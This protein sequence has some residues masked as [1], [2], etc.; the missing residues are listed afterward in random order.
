MLLGD[1][2]R[3]RRDGQ[4]DQ[5]GGPPARWVTLTLTSMSPGRLVKLPGEV[6]A[7]LEAL[8]PEFTKLNAKLLTPG[9]SLKEVSE[10]VR[11]RDSKPID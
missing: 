8:R 9:M 11:F 10:Q 7:K 6:L 4:L 3:R 5:Q 2:Q 1:E